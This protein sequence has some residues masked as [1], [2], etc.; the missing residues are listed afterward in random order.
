MFIVNSHLAV[1]RHPRHV[2][3]HLGFYF[4][5]SLTPAASPHFRL[6][7]NKPLVLYSALQSALNSSQEIFKSTGCGKPAEGKIRKTS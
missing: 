3:E 7:A 2:R 5:V 4:T 6:A 1:Q